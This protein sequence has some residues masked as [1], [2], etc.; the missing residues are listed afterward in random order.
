MLKIEPKL[1]LSFTSTIAGLLVL[2][3]CGGS[4]NPD[5]VLVVGMEL[6]YPP[7]ELKDEIG[8]PKGVSVDLATALGEHLGQNVEI[9]DQAW[10]SL[11]PSLQKGGIDC[12]ISS[13]TITPERAEAVDFSDPYVSNGICMLVP[14]EGEVKSAEDL[15]QPGRTISCK[16]GTTGHLWAQEFLPDA[17]LIVLEDSGNCALEVV[18]GK[19]DAFLYDQVSIYQF[20]KRYPE[21]TDAILKPLRSEVWGIAVKNGNTE[22]LTEINTFLNDYRESG[23]FDRLGDKWLKEWK[24]S[25]EELGVS[26][27]F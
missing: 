14:K 27:V 24:V 17:K 20:W 12:V 26:F 21:Q 6:A 18:Q 13:M 7:F 19:A 3:S 9:R 10:V 22:L 16:L 5:D 4:G 1:L 15:K 23:G 8:Q 11:I 2:T 25:F